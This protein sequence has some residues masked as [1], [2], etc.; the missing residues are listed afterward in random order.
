MSRNRQKKRKLPELQSNKKLQKMN[1][2]KLT[3]VMKK[4][5][6][7]VE[8]NLD[9]LPN[10]QPVNSK[11]RLEDYRNKIGMLGRLI[12]E[13]SGNTNEEYYTRTINSTI[14]EKL[15]TA[16]LQYEPRMETTTK[17]TKATLGVVQTA[18]D[19]LQALTTEFDNLSK[20]C[21]NKEIHYDAAMKQCLSLINKYSRIK[22]EVEEHYTGRRNAGDELSTDENKAYRMFVTK[23]NQVF[24]TKIENEL[25]ASLTDLRRS[26]LKEKIDGSEHL[27]TQ[28]SSMGW[29]DAINN[30][31]N[32]QLQKLDELI[33]MIENPSNYTQEDFAKVLHEGYS[34]RNMSVGANEPATVQT[35]P[36]L[37]EAKLAALD[38]LAPPP[39]LESQR[40]PDNVLPPANNIDPAA[41]AAE[42]RIDIE[43]ARIVRNRWRNDR[44]HHSAY[45]AADVHHTAKNLDSYFSRLDAML[46]QTEQAKYT[47]NLEVAK[48]DKIDHAAADIHL[49][50][51]QLIETYEDIL[52]LAIRHPDELIPNKPPKTGVSI[53]I[54]GVGPVSCP[55]D[56]RTPKGR[57]AFQD[58]IDAAK[59]YL[60][61]IDTVQDNILEAVYLHDNPKKIKHAYYTTTNTDTPAVRIIATGTREDQYK[62][63]ADFINGYLQSPPNITGS[64]GRNINCDSPG[65]KT[66]DPCET[67]VIPMQVTIKQK[68]LFSRAPLIVKT[69]TIQTVQGNSCRS[70]F[71]FSE[72]DPGKFNKISRERSGIASIPGLATMEWAANNMNSF[73]AKMKN[74]NEPVNLDTRTLPKEMTEAFIIYC[75]FKGIK[76]RAPAGFEID[77]KKLAKKV[78]IFAEKWAEKPEHSADIG[79][80]QATELE[81]KTTSPSARMARKP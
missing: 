37:P 11:L 13:K 15:S 58:N 16:I 63:A 66:T 76:Y 23:Q 28:V 2:E 73:R 34:I 5:V 46:L 64:G 22:T 72:N 47:R 45:H 25:P 1:A 61:K 33:N 14:H 59:N 74:L 41:T 49:Q 38:S 62:Q 3:L 67:R 8:Q 35:D 40:P 77:Q 80:K 32:K 54:I 4:Y 78:A 9:A 43:A 30:M 79:I 53:D 75:A 55:E 81:E 12:D 21:R 71:H 6:E 42:E 52:A 17:T 19:A 57:Q 26:D 50:L 24:T 48:M 20:Q 36:L 31:D 39:P 7:S 68:Q 27:R 56:L 60:N 69:V 65:T 51:S 29:Y 18:I 44:L 10:E 70:E